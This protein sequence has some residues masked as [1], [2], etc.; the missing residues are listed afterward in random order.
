MSEQEDISVCVAHLTDL[1][2]T[3][4]EN[5]CQDKKLNHNKK[6]NNR[7]KWHKCAKSGA[8]L[9]EECK[10]RCIQKNRVLVDVTVVS[11]DLFSVS[12]L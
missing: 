8:M 6:K 5:R 1:I 10:D 3:Q 4:V 9:K 2:H 7:H 11:G 12:Q